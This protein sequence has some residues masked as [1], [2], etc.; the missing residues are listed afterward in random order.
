MFFFGL[1]YVE[2]CVESCNFVLSTDKCHAPCVLTTVLAKHSQF[3]YIFCE[4]QSFPAFAFVL[5]SF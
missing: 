5:T 1:E 3:F 4:L 2:Y